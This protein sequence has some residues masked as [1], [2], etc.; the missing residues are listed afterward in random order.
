MKKF[1]LSTFVALSLI[2]CSTIQSG[3][4]KTIDIVGPGVLHKPVIADLTVS[5]NKVSKTVTLSNVQLLDNGKHAAVRELLKENNADV[6]VEPTYESTSRNGVT[7]L[8]VYGW[9][10]KYKNFREIEEK[11]IK[12]L[13]VKPHYLQKAESAQPATQEKK[14]TL[15]WILGGAALLI[16]AAVVATSL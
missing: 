5:Q 15:G 4:S 10:A 9:P 11:D 8:T 13:E 3:T 12:F 2:S 16:G 7:E 14:S 1:L 6:L